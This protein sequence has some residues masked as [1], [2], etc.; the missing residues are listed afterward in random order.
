MTDSPK[1]TAYNQA[2]EPFR[3]DRLRTVWGYVVG[4]A[5]HYG[6]AE[7]PNKIV[8]LHDHKGILTV[9]WKVDGTAGEKEFFSRAW[10]SGIGDFCDNVEHE[11]A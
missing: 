4:L 7:L 6:N 2:T 3:I 1:F 5:D 10:K 11:M 9:R 8:G